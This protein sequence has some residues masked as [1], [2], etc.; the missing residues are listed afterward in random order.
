MRITIVISGLGGGG[1][2]RVCVNLANAWAERGHAV[3]ILTV[4]QNS[5]TP[6]Y[7]IDP[8]VEQRDV[9]WPREANSEELDDRAIE[10]MSSGIKR[11][12][13]DELLEQLTLLAMLRHSI[14]ATTPDVVVAHLDITN[15]RVLAAM[16][17]TG[18][19]VIACEHTDTTQVSVGKWQRHREAFYR[20]AGAV[21]AP[22]PAIAGWLARGGAAAYAIPNPLVTPPPMCLKPTGER[23]RLVTLTRL[24]PEKRVELL[25]R[26]FAQ[27]AGDFP[28]WD[29][30]VYGD[31]PLRVS[32]EWLVGELA[33]GRVHL[34]GFIDDAYGIL[35]GA[36]LLVSA[37]WVEGF[38]NAI[39]E[40]LA[41]GVPVVAMECGAPVRSLVDDGVN[42]LI[43]REDSISALA[44]ALK[45]LMGDDTTRK[46]FAARAP[47]I[48][49]RF[50]IESSLRAWDALLNEV[51]GGR[52]G[53]RPEAESGGD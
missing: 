13:C 10:A 49:T 15:V 12:G 26:A 37:S 24:S 28:E 44:S 1:A 29:L 45:S 53:G 34:H 31:G 8:R 51:V 39:W 17:G 35:G 42:G 43:V 50:S 7:A 2:E 36:D 22:H 3:L 9:G 30:E 27:I 18:V 41:C 47:E 52:E 4:S 16:Q 20:D 19:P 23:R 6:A 48:L 21:V 5:A 25:I 38:G 14:L 11:A 33:P 32:L 40:A 46:A